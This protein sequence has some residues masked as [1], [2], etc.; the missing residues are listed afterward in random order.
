MLL[1]PLKVPIGFITWWSGFIAGIP[2][3]WVLCN[4][5]QGTPDLRDKFVQGA[6]NTYIPGATGGTVQH[7]H[8]FTADGHFHSII[9]GTDLPGLGVSPKKAFTSTDPII[10]TTDLTDN[11]PPWYSLAYVMYIGPEL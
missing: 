3:G 5:T 11:L 9:A 7:V 8:N 1:S 4:G 2:T 10:G 6:S